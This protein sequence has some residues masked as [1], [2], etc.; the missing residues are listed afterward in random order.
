MAATKTKRALPEF[1]ARR[2][3]EQ[4]A[5][6]EQLGL[7]LR[8]MMPFPEPG[9]V[10]PAE[11]ICRHREKICVL[12]WRVQ[13]LRPHSVLQLLILGLESAVAK[14][15]FRIS[16][17]PVTLHLP[18]IAS[19]SVPSPSL[20]F[21]FMRLR[22]SKRKQSPG[23]AIIAPG[24]N[25]P[26]PRPNGNAMSGIY[27]YIA[28]QP[29]SPP[30]ITIP[31]ANQRPLSAQSLREGSQISLEWTSGVPAPMDAAWIYSSQARK[32]VPLPTFS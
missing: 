12:N 31:R 15:A 10:R 22:L 27:Q 2:K 16:S 7:K 24:P 25:L 20:L 21:S 19:H 14:S 4:A 28:N 18:P 32:A 3:A 8:S 17:S 6:I 13:V 29:P 26:T 30:T 23:C 5:H 11:R 1:L 9:R